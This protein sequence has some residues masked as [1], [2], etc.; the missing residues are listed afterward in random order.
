MN[1][2][3][4]NNVPNSIKKLWNNKSS[5]N[6]KKKTFNIRLITKNPA[7]RKNYTTNLVKNPSVRNTKNITKKFKTNLVKNPRHYTRKN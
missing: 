2:K 1:W 3:G 5:M 4:R 7:V 6:N